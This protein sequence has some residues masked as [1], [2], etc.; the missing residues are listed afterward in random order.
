ATAA[1]R[2]GVADGE[3]GV[4]GAGV[5]DA[6][7]ERLKLRH[8]CRRGRGRA[9]VAAFDGAGRDAAGD[10]RRGAVIDVDRLAGG[11]GVAAA[12]ALRVHD[13]LP[14]WA[15]AAGRVGVADGEAGVG[16]AGVADAQ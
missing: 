3:A 10:R 2:V 15:T 9:A 11:A 13:A 1:G 4:G 5:A 14:I 8:R 16:G 6:Q 7:A 12:I